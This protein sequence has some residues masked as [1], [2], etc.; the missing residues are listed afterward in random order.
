MA[1][2]AVA[3]DAGGFRG[4]CRDHGSAHWKPS[5]RRRA[6]EYEGA[7]EGAVEEVGL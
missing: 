6:R 4:F 2:V 3:V 7:E 1:P 5:V